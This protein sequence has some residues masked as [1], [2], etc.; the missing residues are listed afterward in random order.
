MVCDSSCTCKSPKTYSGGR[1]DE[2]VVAGEEEE[3]QQQRQ[4][5]NVKVK[6]TLE[7]ATNAL[8]GSRCIALLFL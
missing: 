2:G 8:R 1:G 5:Q 6:F 4:Q 7:H 3:Q